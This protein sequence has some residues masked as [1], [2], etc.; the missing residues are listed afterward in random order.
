MKREI[1]ALCGS[2]RFRDEFREVE[3]FLTLEGKIPLP[4]AIYGK[5]E[6]IKYSDKLSKKLWKLHVDKIK[7]S[8]GIFVID[9]DGYMGES[10]RKEISLAQKNGKFVRYYSQ[11]KDRIEKLLSQ[12]E[13]K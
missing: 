10:T 1:V 2:T 11:E 7:I 5:A 4:P 6:G 3:R 12:G 9:V 13:L 8:D